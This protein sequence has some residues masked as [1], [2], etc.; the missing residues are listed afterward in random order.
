[1][2]GRKLGPTACR[3]Y[4]NTLL[5][6][7]ER[8]DV[9]AI[10]RWAFCFDTRVDRTELKPRC[11]ES[12][13]N[14]L[15]GVHDGPKVAMPGD[16]LVNGAGVSR[17][18]WGQST[19]SGSP[20]IR[21]AVTRT[22][23]LGKTSLGFFENTRRLPVGIHGFVQ[24][25]WRSQCGQR[26]RFPYGNASGHNLRRHQTMTD[27]RLGVHDLQSADCGFESHRPHLIL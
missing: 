6:C 22:Q 18:R 19:I 16:R 7:A 20:L 2:E 24:C 26:V 23:P 4:I 14:C 13:S 25:V 15:L 5:R 9:S 11:L 1:M 27:C 3:D 12:Q 21:T 8:H 17:R 10:L